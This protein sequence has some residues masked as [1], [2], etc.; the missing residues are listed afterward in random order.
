MAYWKGEEIMVFFQEGEPQK[1]IVLNCERGRHGWKLLCQPD[2]AEA[3]S[4]I[5]V[6]DSEGRTPPPDNSVLEIQRT[7]VVRT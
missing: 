2:D 1:V 7:G 3:E 6:W 4:K 5:V